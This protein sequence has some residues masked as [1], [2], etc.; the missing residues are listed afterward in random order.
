MGSE[1]WSARDRKAALFAGSWHRVRTRAPK[2]AVAGGERGWRER[3]GRIDEPRIELEFS[4]VPFSALAVASFFFSPPT[5]ERALA[6]LRRVEKKPDFFLATLLCYLLYGTPVTDKYN[7]HSSP[8]IVPDEAPRA[9]GLLHFFHPSPSYPFFCLT[10]ATTTTSAATAIIAAATGGS[11]ASAPPPRR[12]RRRH[13]C[14]THTRGARQLSFLL[15]AFFGIFPVAPSIVSRFVIVIRLHPAKRERGEGS[16]TG[17]HRGL[18]RH[19]PPQPPPPISR[20]RAR[21]RPCPSASHPRLL[22]LSPGYPTP[23]LTHTAPPCFPTPTSGRPTP[24]PDA[25][26]CVPSALADRD[27]DDDDDES[28]AGASSSQPR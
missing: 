7:R 5:S 8:R 12:H 17:I 15:F 10:A 27:R 21:P 6:A 16:R 13:H 28:V 4:F 1:G 3:A 24:I 25:L 11:V 19:L 22:V 9:P 20:P 18:Q 26:L 23:E 2:Q 14:G